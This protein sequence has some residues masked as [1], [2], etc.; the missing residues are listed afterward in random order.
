MSDSIRSVYGKTYDYGEGAPAFYPA[1]GGS[2]DWSHLSGI[3]ISYTIELRDTGF[4]GF[5]LPESQIK[6][7]ALENIEGIRDVYDHVRPSGFPCKQAVCLATKPNSEC[8]YSLG[9][10][11]H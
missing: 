2:D 1:S 10:Y 5:A 4:Y 7:T 9:V 6:P 11:K 3:D 8:K